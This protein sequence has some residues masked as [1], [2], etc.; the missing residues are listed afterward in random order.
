MSLS[1]VWFRQDLRLADNPALHAAVEK[2]NPLLLVYVLDD[3]PLSP[4]GL[5]GASGWWLHHSLMALEKDIKALGGQ[6]ILRKG[7]A[8]EVIDTLTR[9]YAINQVFWNRCYEPLA[10]ARDRAL[11]IT[12]E[13]RGITCHSFNG[14]LLHEP[15]KLLNQAGHPFKVFTPFWKTCLGT[16]S[17]RYPLPAPKRLTCHLPCESEPLN[18]WGLLPQHPNWANGFESVWQVGE[19]A[20]FHRL[21]SFIEKHIT[22]YKQLRDFPAGDHTS[23]LS[24][25][26]HFGEISPHQIW[27]GVMAGAD[28]QQ[29]GPQCFLSEVGWREFCSHLLYHFP[30]LPEAPF[31]ESFHHFPWQEN[32]VHLRAWQQ[33]R[34]GY[35]I[36]DAGMRQLWHLGWMHNRVRMIVGS[37]LTKDLMIPWQKGAAWFWDTLVDADL[38]NN[39]GGWQWIAGC[40]AD[41]QPYFRVF[42][43]ILQGEK[44]DPEGT[45]VKTWVPELRNL[46]QT[47][48]HKPW[49]AP[50]GLLD[51][52]GMTLGKTY[53]TPIVDHDHQRKLALD[54]YKQLQ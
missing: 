43:P 22:Q 19:K 38:A 2:G 46:P 4:W 51:K 9:T 54:A 36:V 18:G 40:G 23:R 21:E 48:I 52:A 33:G 53:P 16:L 13:E 5:G 35:P 41:A 7:K 28:P 25:H 6:L 10:I 30:H 34:T 8:D 24:P 44:F 37:F 20:A 32:E 26:L 45:Y 50:Q 49:Q 17:P 14:S 3:E 12:L 47:Y 29:A 39:S 15:V 1:L 11:K 42:N 31:K 27:H